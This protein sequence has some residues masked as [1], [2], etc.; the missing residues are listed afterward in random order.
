MIRKCVIALTLSAIA[1]CS[2]VVVENPT[3]KFSEGQPVSKVEHKKLGE[4]SGGAASANN[5]GY[6]WV[7]NDSGND[8][9]LFLVDEKL[10]IHATCVLPV[11]NRDWE[12]MAIG[13]GP[14]AG[15]QY[16]YLGEIGDN[17]SRFATK[18]VYRF[19]EPRWDRKSSTIS[20]GK[21]DT[22]AFRLEGGTKDTETLLLDPSTKDLYIISKREEPV[23]VYV[24]DFPY[25]TSGINT[26]RR[27]FSIPF[28]QI[29]SGDIASDGK[30]ILLKNYEH[31]YFWDNDKNLSV[32]ELLKQRPFEVPY[33][34][35]PQGETIM[36]ARDRSGFYTVSEKNTGK[37]SYLYLYKEKDAAK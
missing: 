29:V 4:I 18:Y 15:K 37:T 30:N 23:W 12:D 6:F 14:E 31:I 11:E 22:I 17:I 34:L 7:H 35:E 33:I 21:I 1:A 10:T 9:E 8:P 5:E 26:A 24:L 3:D 27:L 36:W 2:K 28:T 32:P 13:P 25:A 16:I 20:P 19:E